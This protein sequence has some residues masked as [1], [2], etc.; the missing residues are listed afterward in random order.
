MKPPSQLLVVNR[1]D[2]G[3][4]MFSSFS[5]GLPQ[6]HACHLVY[7][8]GLAVRDDQQALAMGSTT[9]G[10]WT[11]ADAGETLHCVSRDLPLIAAVTFAA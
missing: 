5:D 8:H 10:L 9:R 2:N 6:L 3:G 11:S 4:Q 1:T 7:R